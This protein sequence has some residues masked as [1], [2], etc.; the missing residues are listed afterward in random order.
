MVDLC[1]GR[2][3]SCDIFLKCATCATSVKN[4]FSFWQERW[5][6]GFWSDFNVLTRIE[7]GTRSP[8]PH[9]SEKLPKVATLGYWATWAGEQKKLDRGYE[10]AI[11]RQ[12]IP[13]C[14]TIMVFP[15]KIAR[16]IQP[17]IMAQKPRLALPGKNTGFLNST[18]TAIAKKLNFR[19]TSEPM[20]STC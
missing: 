15:L 11:L 2:R 17:P 12:T 7:I 5:I 3:A 6:P 20:L 14:S 10:R 1:H 9:W 13:R 16:C 19:T 18:A 8:K 4:F